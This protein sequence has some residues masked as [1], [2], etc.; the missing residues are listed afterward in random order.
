MVG[1]VGFPRK[2]TEPRGQIYELNQDG[3]TT[4]V[5][6]II[7][8]NAFRAAFNA[9]FMEILP[10]GP[11]SLLKSE[12][13]LMVLLLKSTGNFGPSAVPNS[14]VFP[15]TARVRSQIRNP[16]PSIRISLSHSH[17]VRLALSFYP[18][19]YRRE[20]NPKHSNINNEGQCGNFR[21][22]G[23]RIAINRSLVITSL[24]S[25]QEKR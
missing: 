10:T 17:W 6:A 22:P 1:A 11:K 8:S 16:Q 19:V 13:G 5:Y 3:F 2:S 25:V 4:H 21:F 18:R 14:F 15:A 23:R 9:I 20:T 12:L 24:F 7:Y